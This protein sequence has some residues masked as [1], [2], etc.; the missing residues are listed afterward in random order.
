MK[1]KDIVT[2]D[3]KMKI[4]HINSY[5][6]GS[7]F[8]KNLYDKQIEDKL[9]I[10]V[11]VPVPNDMGTSKLNLGEYTNISH[12]HGKYDRILFHLKHKKIYDDIL[13]K[14]SI[15]DYNL[16]H[17]HSLFSNGFIAYRL[18]K[19]HQIPYIV[20]VRNTD[21]NVFF[22]RM[23]HLRKLGIDILKNAKKIVFISKTYMDH[24]I[25]AYVPSR[26]KEAFLEK[27]VV[28]PNGIDQFWLENKFAKREKPNDKAINLLYV[29]VVD[30]NKNIEATIKACEILLDEGFDIKYTIIGKIKMSSKEL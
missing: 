24:L 5:Y 19:K 20:A 26:Y 10:D 9:D 2:G 8:Y 28:I 7:F 4:L 23:I 27:S 3:F 30:K 22:K 14:Y 18:Y 21:I 17:A 25:E 13:K 29:G 6:S 11:Y 12:N 1:K 16:I 15:E